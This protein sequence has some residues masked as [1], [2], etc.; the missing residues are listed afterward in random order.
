MSARAPARRRGSGPAR[1]AATPSLAA[2]PTLPAQFSSFVGRGEELA[3]VGGL[4]GGAR[5]VTLTGA[6]GVGKT[7]LAIEAARRQAG[8]VCF[9]DLAPLGDGAE[10]AQVVI[11]ALGL[12]ESGPL[13]PVSGSP[14]SAARLV[15]GLAGRRMLLV[16]DNCWVPAPSCGCWPPAGRRWAS[17]ANRCARCRRSRSRRSEPRPR[18]RLVIRPYGCSPIGSPRCD[19]GSR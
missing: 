16:L 18:R 8:E 3:R 9:V 2:R 4:L 17:R 11:A 19:R 15:A 5:L 1:P 6:G 14:D 13:P 7:R 10:V 12:R